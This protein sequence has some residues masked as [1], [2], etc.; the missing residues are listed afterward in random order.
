[1]IKLT[2]TPD[3]LRNW[4]FGKLSVA[5]HQFAMN[6]SATYWCET[7]TAMFVYQ[8]AE[9]ATRS[10]TIDTAALLA[11][12]APMHQSTWGDAISMAT[13]G[14]TVRDAL[15]SFNTVSA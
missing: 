3:T 13:V 15:D 2:L 7:I 5:Q 9:Y 11:K 4:A 1:M 8:Q 12:L 6:P 14:M 10:S